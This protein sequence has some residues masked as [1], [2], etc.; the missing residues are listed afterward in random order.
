MRLDVDHG[1]KFCRL[2]RIRIIRALAEWNQFL[3]S[4]SHSLEM[5][6]LFGLAAL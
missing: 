1:H 3:R 2:D 6:R 5:H 4:H